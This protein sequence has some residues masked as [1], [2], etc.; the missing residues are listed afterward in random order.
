M[1]SKIQLRILILNFDEIL[2]FPKIMKNLPKK[3][4]KRIATARQ[5][6]DKNYVIEM[7]EK[8]KM[9]KQKEKEKEG[10]KRRNRDEK[11]KVKII[12]LLTKPKS[13]ER[14]TKKTTRAKQI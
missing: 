9:K 6:T 10:R 14:T 12:N 3:K 8:I 7:Q 13:S 4:T 2:V 5:L 1:D 11:R